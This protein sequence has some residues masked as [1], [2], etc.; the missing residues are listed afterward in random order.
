M[1]TKEQYKSLNKKERDVYSYVEANKEKA[2]YMNIRELAHVCNV[3]TA[4]ILR[5]I[6]KLGYESYKEYKF[7]NRKEDKK[8]FYYHTSEII[9]CL[10]KMETPY[11][12]ELLQEAADMIN[13][14]D[15]IVVG[16]VGNNIGIATY[17]ARCFSNKGKFAL[18]LND[19]FYNIE[20]LPKNIIYI[21]LSVSGETKEMIQEVNAFH[22]AGTPI[23][24]ISSKE[25]STIGKMADLNLSYYL[26]E[27][28][29][30]QVFDGASQI[31]AISIIERLA[32]KIYSS[33]T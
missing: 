20:S 30:N 14:S 24:C 12:E 10:M 9:D 21:C 18:S 3:S 8:V 33:N 28:R 22:K 7:D 13:A 23:L 5:F 32:H 2:S 27:Q 1:I 16:G 4:T 11:F 25:D 6:H 29:K 26:A 15:L 19:P 17:A 31:P